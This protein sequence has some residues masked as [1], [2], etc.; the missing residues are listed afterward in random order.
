MQ[1]RELTQ[2]DLA[3]QLGVTQAAVS[4]WMKG[5]PPGADI[6]VRIANLFSVSTDFLLL[7]KTVTKLEPDIQKEKPDME[8]H[9][10]VWRKLATKKI[11]GMSPQDQTTFLRAVSTLL[12]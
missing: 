6:V 5:T 9:L 1:G 11:E 7:G 3:K 2:A 4:K 12:R 10:V 8:E